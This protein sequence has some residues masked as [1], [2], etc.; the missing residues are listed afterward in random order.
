MSPA[1]LPFAQLPAPGPHPAT[2]ELR[3]YAAGTLA[4]AQ[5]H[6]IEAHTLDCERCADLLE[7]FA[8]TDATT[9]DQAVA[10]LRTRLHARI[11]SPAAEP[12]ATGWAW[13]HIAAAAALVGVVGSG[14]WS[15]EQREPA[16][17]PEIARLETSAPAAPAAP[18][19]AAEPTPL[20]ADMASASSAV[21][22]AESEVP[23]A[24]RAASAA[25]TRA[26]PP[27]YAATVPPQM[28]RR[29]NAPLRQ[30]SASAPADYAVLADAAPAPAS[31]AVVEEVTEAKEPAS[32]ANATVADVKIS[33]SAKKMAMPA[34]AKS[35]ATSVAT[36][37]A[38]SAT[39]DRKNLTA[40][41]LNKSKTAINSLAA[42]NAAAASVPNTPMPAALAIN[43]MPVGGTPALRDYIRRQVAEFEPEDGATRIHGTVR[44]KFTVG[45]DGK[46]SNLTVVRGMRPDY[47]EEALRM[48]CEG[49]AWQ[50]GIAAGRR[51]P[52]PIELTVTF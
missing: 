47:D 16:P 3:A 51:T 18:K 37:V 45:A 19:Q 2:A 38:D 52:L 6:R 25:K 24:T 46:V 23:P 4:P 32:V 11:S 27:E 36:V 49:P 15:W 31:S 21:A 8:M 33:A 28:A 29:Y 17:K 43:P 40:N 13:P 34:A 7:G 42:D 30:A 22:M 48:V 44:L 10:G 50:P 5:E 14:I 20:S 9:T 12:A 35:E 41:S 39:N 1:D 26:R